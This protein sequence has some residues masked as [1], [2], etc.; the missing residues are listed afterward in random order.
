MLKFALVTPFLLLPT[1]AWAQAA[2][3]TSDILS[4]TD[5]DRW[6]IG[7][8]VSVRDSAYAGEGTR[9]RPLPIVTYEGERLFWR[10]L[11]GGVHAIKGDTFNLDV[12]LA[13]RFDGFDIDDLGRTALARNGLDASLLEDR[14]DGLD[15]GLAASWRGRAGEFKLQALADVTDA[16]GGYEFAA[17]YAYALHWGRTTIVPGV[18][19]RWMSADLVDYYDGTLDEEVARGVVRYQPGSAVVPQ[20]SVGFSRPLGRTWK[21]FGAVDYKFL[22]SEISDSPLIEPDTDGTAGVRIGLSRGF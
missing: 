11:S 13:G 17:D 1:L 10:G 7:V 5:D 21:L 2:T 4:T 22:P 20:V 12:V 3:S 16:S 14:D 6:T 15:A 19:V 18:G 9:V 8:G